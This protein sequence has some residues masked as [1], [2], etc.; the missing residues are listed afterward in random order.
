MK[1]KT[2][3]VSVISAFAFGLACGALGVPNASA[4][5]KPAVKPTPN[6]VVPSKPAPVPTA[7]SVSTAEDRKTVSITVYNQNFGLVREVRELPALGSG[8]VELEFRDVAA[9]IQPETVNIK[10]VGAGGLSVLEQNYRFDL[11]SP[12]T[13]LEKYVGKRVRAYRYHEQTGKEDVVDAD[14][15]SIEGGP[16]LK[17]NNEITFGYPARL[18]FPEVPDNLIAKPTLVWLVDS[19]AAKQTV[20]VTY[21]TQNLNWSADYVLVVDDAE[22]KGDLT[23]WVTLVNQSGA[24]YKNAELKLVAGDVNRVQPPPA[25][26]MAYGAAMSKAARAQPQFQ[27]Q[28]LFEYHLYSLQ[29]PTSVLQN[30]QKQVNLLTAPGIGVNKKLIFYGQQYWFR[31]QYGQVMS[32]QKVGVYLDIQNSEQNRLGMPLPKGTLRVYKADKS[33]AKQFVGE[34]A[35][36]HT[37]RDE[38]LRVK[39]GEAFDVVGDRKQ[40]EW[41]ELGGCVSESAWEIEVRNHKDTPV[42]VEDYEPVG[43][44]WTMVSS[45]Q[46]AEKK[47]ASTFTFNIK[48][49]ARGTTKVNYKVRVRWC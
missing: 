37:P 8:K 4:E 25:A 47:D 17:F 20:E 29:R 18:A 11:L 28:G 42:E 19:A 48:V 16:I 12:Q 26:P 5:P 38:K 1:M 14:L 39:M 40:T 36:D 49:P 23:G 34:D 24:S 7:H 45:S 30:E 9:N 35:I 22:K 43:G 27:E 46:T 21:L 10:A 2:K 32:N 6:A 33:G 3:Q 44:D 31:G 15:L 41:H 13:L